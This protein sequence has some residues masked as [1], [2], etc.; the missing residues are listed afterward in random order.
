MIMV[1]IIA[2]TMIMVI[3]GLLLIVVI[4]VFMIMAGLLLIMV[5]IIAA[6]AQTEL[7]RTPSCMLVMFV[8]MVL[9]LLRV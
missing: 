7:L 1:M 2:I 3:A 8:A 9:L 5:M 6:F 4:I